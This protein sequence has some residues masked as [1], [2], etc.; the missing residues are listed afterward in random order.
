MAGD[1]PSFATVDDLRARWPEVDDAA[2]E[3]TAQTVLDDAS[4]AIEAEE[5]F[6][7]E[8]DGGWSKKQAAALRAVC[9]ELARTALET[10]PEYY[11]ATQA[12]VT[13]GPYSRTFA[14][15]GASGNIYLTKAQKARLGIG[16]PDIGYASPWGLS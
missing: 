15:S 1:A 13:A 14:Y 5:P 16:R 7:G 8:P 4:A 6:G 10:A 9:C 11:G 3:A 12:T 2:D